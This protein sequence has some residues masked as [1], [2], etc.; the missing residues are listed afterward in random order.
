MN[1]DIGRPL[2]FIILTLIFF[3]S[4]TTLIYPEFVVIYWVFIMITIPILLLLGISELVTRKYKN[5]TPQN[6]TTSQLKK[7]LVTVIVFILI[8]ILLNF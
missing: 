8:M 7:S 4:I 5:T 2:F 1:K 6:S 3:G